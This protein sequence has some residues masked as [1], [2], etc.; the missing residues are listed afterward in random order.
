[1]QTIYIRFLNEADRARGFYQLALRVGISSLPGAVYQI[2]REAL[3]ILDDEHIT[4][5]H[6]TEAEIKDAHD[7]VRNPSAAVL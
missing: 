5:R 4:Y 1:M 7:Q 6:A 3:K 2:R